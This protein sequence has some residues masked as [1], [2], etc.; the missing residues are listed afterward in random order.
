MSLKPRSDCSALTKAFP[1]GLTRQLSQQSAWS[2]DLGLN[3]RTYVE[4][5]SQAWWSAL[6]IPVL[7]EASQPVS[8]PRLT[9]EPTPVR[10]SCS[11]SKVDPMMA[12]WV[13][14]LAAK[15]DNLGLMPRIHW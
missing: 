1:A 4:E 15:P 3:P 8:L 7:P 2:K 10:D 9:E 13:K 12:S 14:A 11:K 6:I 5:E